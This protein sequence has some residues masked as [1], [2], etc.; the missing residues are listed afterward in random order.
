MNKV[1]ALIPV[2]MLE[3]PSG[4]SEAM[5]VGRQV[6]TCPEEFRNRDLSEKQ[7]HLVIKVSAA[8]TLTPIKLELQ[9]KGKLVVLSLIHI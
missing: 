2:E 7:K 4:R 6:E 8:Q 9:S 3:I 5:S 1:D